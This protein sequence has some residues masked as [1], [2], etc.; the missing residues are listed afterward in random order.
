MLGIIVGSGDSVTIDE[1]ANLA[2]MET[3]ARIIR[4]AGEWHDRNGYTPYAARQ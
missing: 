2:A 1:Q 3:T 4:R